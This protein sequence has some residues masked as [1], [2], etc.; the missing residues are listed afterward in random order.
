MAKSEE[1]KLQEFVE[2]Q[3]EKVKNAGKAS[4]SVSEVKIENTDDIPKPW[5][6]KPDEIS[7]R[8]QIGWQQ[9]PINDL[10]TKG[11][12]YPEGAE[13]V[14]R[15]A[16]GEEIRHWSTLNE[17]DLSAT[18]DMLNYILER[19]V[20]IKFA[21]KSLSS[22]RDIKEVD[23]FYILLAVS[24]LTMIEGE[25]KLQI[26]VSEKEKLTVKKDMIDFINFDD[27]IMRFYNAKERLFVLRFKSGP[28]MK[29]SIPSV[30][31]T[32]WLKNYVIRQRQTQQPIDED[33]LTYAPFVIT[34]WRGLSDDSYSKYVEDSN[35]SLS[36]VSVL[37]EVKNIFLETINPQVKYTDENGG[38]R[39]LPLNFQGGLKSI[40]LISDPFG[41]L[42]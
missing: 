17:T 16:V 24:E 23:R 25:H 21:D 8:N 39:S 36:E 9:I 12:F 4:V 34:D 42:V 40:F 38:E 22:W 5:E 37:N 14:I 31:V 33:F 35:W 1:Q 29:L 6:K 30:G 26:K 41:E 2:N 27:R 7:A 11:M 32:N 18:D 3:E 15:S 28:T 19:C 10:P 13:I 20:Q